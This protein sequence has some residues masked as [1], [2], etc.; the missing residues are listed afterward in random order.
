[1]KRLCSVNKV[2]PSLERGED[3]YESEWL[4]VG[5]LHELLVLVDVTAVSGTTHT[6]NV[7]LQTS[8]NASNDFDHTVPTDGEMN[9]ISKKTVPV[10]NFGKFVRLKAVV[11]GT[12]TP[13]VTFEAFIVAKS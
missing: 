13:T 9:S 4:H 12:D 11:A 3:T 8:P 10:T 2:F 7:T 1:M 6:L 5:S